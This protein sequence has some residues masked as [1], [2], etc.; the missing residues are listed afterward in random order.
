M[1]T[2]CNNIL[3][4]SLSQRNRKHEK[5]RNEVGIFSFESIVAAT[6]NF[7]D[8][9]RLGEGGFGPVYKIIYM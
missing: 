4:V 6:N 2:P 8:S 3:G 7:F 5:E 9:S 1:R